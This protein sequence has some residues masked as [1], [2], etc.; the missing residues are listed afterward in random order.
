MECDK[1]F[2]DFAQDMR[3][4]IGGTENAG[5][6]GLDS[7]EKWCPS[8]QFAFV[9]AFINFDLDGF[10]LEPTR[11]TTIVERLVE[12]AIRSGAASM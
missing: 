2:S 11:T 6:I 10:K 12:N 5:I 7:R 8:L 1:A 4:E 9:V 3:V